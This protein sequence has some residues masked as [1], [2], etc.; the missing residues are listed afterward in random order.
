MFDLPVPMIRMPQ[1]PLFQEPR[2]M[3]VMQHM[4]ASLEDL[5]QHVLNQPNQLQQ[6]FHF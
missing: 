2:E 3:H 5:E 6:Q 1:H 4:L